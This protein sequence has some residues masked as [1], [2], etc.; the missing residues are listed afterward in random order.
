MSV[1]V[2]IT[3][4]LCRL[5]PDCIGFTLAAAL[6]LTAST[7]M[8]LPFIPLFVMDVLLFLQIGITQYQFTLIM[9]IQ[10]SRTRN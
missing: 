3:E 6:I 2:M 1:C 5:F 10:D 4:P 9:V 7:L 8:K